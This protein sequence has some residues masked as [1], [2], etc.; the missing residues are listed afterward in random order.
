MISKNVFSTNNNTNYNDYI[1]LRKGTEILKTTI[2]NNKNI[3]INKFLNYNDF[4]TISTSYYNFLN[5][6]EF[7]T[8]NTR[9]LKNANI[10]YVIK[11]GDDNIADEMCYET[12]KITNLRFPTNLNLEKWCTK[13]IVQNRNVNEKPEINLKNKT[14]TYKINLLKRKIIQDYLIPC[15]SKQWK[16]INENIFFINGFIDK[17]QKYYDM[18]KLDD[19]LM[20]IE[21]LKIVKLL[22]EK[23]NLLVD[24]EKQINGSNQNNDI[25]TMIYKTTAIK[26]LPEYEIYNSILG[27]PN[28]DLNEKYN[29]EIINDIKRLMEL[30]NITYNKIKEYIEHHYPPKVQH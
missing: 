28:K 18:Y 27:K 30:D 7:E 8:Y 6:D 15:L 12:N 13:R 9:N 22:V 11:N 29:T 19:V 14:I 26:L 4:H 1:K 20:Y 23:H 10:S 24:T 25:L 5:Y 16:I 21:I 2:N 17:L 3:T